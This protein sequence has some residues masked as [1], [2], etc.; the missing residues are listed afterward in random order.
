ML[1]LDGIIYCIYGNL[2]ILNRPLEWQSN[3]HIRGSPKCIKESFPSGF[4]DLLVYR[5]RNNFRVVIINLTFASSS[6]PLDYFI[7]QR[8]YHYV[9]HCYRGL[10][11]IKIS[12]LHLIS[13]MALECYNL[14]LL[15][16][17][18]HL[19]IQCKTLYLYIT[20]AVY[21]YCCFIVKESQLH[22]F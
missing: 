15:M 3:H 11:L 1:K 13:Y 14:D 10:K 16:H 2:N 4:F 21:L 18:T 9:L 22:D 5:G 12:V 8:I 7:I 19:R 17:N 20:L 6:K